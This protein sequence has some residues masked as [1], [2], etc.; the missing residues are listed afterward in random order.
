M[1][2]GERPLGIVT[3]G[4]SELGHRSILEMVQSEGPPRTGSLGRDGT[5]PSRGAEGRP[6]SWEQRARGRISG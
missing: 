5:W 3:P 6:G 1:G 4:G 2:Q